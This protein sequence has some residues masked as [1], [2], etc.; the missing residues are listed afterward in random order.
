MDMSLHD[1]LIYLCYNA[2]KIPHQQKEALLTMPYRISTL[3][4]P[5]HIKSK[6][7]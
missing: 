1:H 5:Y 4:M 3:Q 6:Y 2:A 7:I